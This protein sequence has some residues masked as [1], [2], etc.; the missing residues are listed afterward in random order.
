MDSAPCTING[1]IQKTSK[2][3]FGPST[4]RSAL[5]SSTERQ[6]PVSEL[7]KYVSAQNILFFFEGFLAWARVGIHEAPRLRYCLAPAHRLIQGW[8][9]ALR[10]GLVSPGT[11][12][13]LLPP[14]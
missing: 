1:S 4:I 11:W 7:E 12:H 9:E 5:Q 10:A 2:I 13:Y 8:K 14:R 3:S 6:T